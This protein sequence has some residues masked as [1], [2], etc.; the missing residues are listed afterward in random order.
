MIP[1]ATARAMDPVTLIVTALGAGAGSALQD[2]TSM[3]VKDACARLKSL[4]K[5][6]FADRPKGQLALAAPGRGRRH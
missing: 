1:A 6:R 2:Q 4:V 5:E 3:V